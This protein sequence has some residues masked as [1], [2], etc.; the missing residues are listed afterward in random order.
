MEELETFD[1]ERVVVPRDHLL[2]MYRQ[3]L[4]VFGYFYKR[5]AARRGTL[6]GQEPGPEYF[7]WGPPSQYSLL[8]PV[9]AE[10]HLV[11]VL[12]LVRRESGDF[13]GRD[14]A[15]G[16][17]LSHLLSEALTNTEARAGLRRLRI[18][19]L[20]RRIS[21]FGEL[22]LREIGRHYASNAVWLLRPDIVAGAQRANGKQRKRRVSRSSVRLVDEARGELYCMGT[23]DTRLGGEWP[24]YIARRKLP[25]AMESKQVLA[26]RR[27]KPVLVVDTSAE[28]AYPWWFADTRSL[29]VAPIRPSRQAKALGVISVSV[30]EGAYSQ[31]DADLLLLLAAHSSGPIRAAQDREMLERREKQWS[32]V[33]KMGHRMQ[34]TG[35]ALGDTALPVRPSFRRAA[36]MWAKQLRGMG[37]GRVM[38]GTVDPVRR[39]VQGAFGS[40]DRMQEV[41]DKTRCHFD[42]QAGDVQVLVVKTTSWISID[43]PPNDPRAN[44]RTVRQYRIG[45]FAV[46]PLLVG[47][48]GDKRVIGTVHIERAD[49]LPITEEEIRQDLMPLADQLAVVLQNSR[50]RA[51][52]E[53]IFQQMGEPAFVVD[54]GFRIFAANTRLGDVLHKRQ[55]DVI[56]RECYKALMGRDA[57]CED[58][59]VADLQPGQRGPSVLR[60]MTVGS[61]GGRV[62]LQESAAPVSDEQDVQI[63]FA[64]TAR[65]LTSA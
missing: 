6:I 18:A 42:R 11:A 9:F 3:K 4:G 10:D 5:R 27:G 26:L 2:K 59:V 36:E 57:R 58:C 39:V 52:R 60:E 16:T 19:C 51:L 54:Q 34:A 40:G 13:T 17:A 44:R 14:E 21:L 28:P 1:G 23:H 43:D 7:A 47:R 53:A 56:G 32:L 20:D 30:T 8:L 12:V 49:R 22:T 31:R 45:P 37:Y 25:L 62:Y 24:R 46:L 50:E 64:V 15:L 41:C 63:G 65:E 29:V 48:G 55:T 35:S 33:A 38:I 61:R